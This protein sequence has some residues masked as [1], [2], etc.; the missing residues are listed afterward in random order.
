MM[1]EAFIFKGLQL[2]SFLSLSIISYTRENT[3]FQNMDLF[4]SL[5]ERVELHLLNCVWYKG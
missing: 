3:M 1:E 2:L 4:P 5:V